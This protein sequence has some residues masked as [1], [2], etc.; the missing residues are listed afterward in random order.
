MGRLFG[1]ARENY[2]AEL[3]FI[4]IEK[5][6]S[7]HEYKGAM[8]DDVDM[9]GNMSPISEARAYSSLSNPFSS[10]SLCCRPW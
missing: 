9:Y 2:I 4:M 7:D 8:A 5:Y 1:R 6:S 3:K 10:P